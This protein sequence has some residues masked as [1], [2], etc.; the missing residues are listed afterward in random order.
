LR[1]SDFKL[2]MQQFETSSGSTIT[3]Y[4]KHDNNTNHVEFMCVPGTYFPQIYRYLKFKP[5]EEE[6]VEYEGGYIDKD[7]AFYYEHNLCYF[8]KPL[9]YKNK[10]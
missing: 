5:I 8:A 6:Y 1:V 2:L 7:L 4:E 3:V 9:K 10:I